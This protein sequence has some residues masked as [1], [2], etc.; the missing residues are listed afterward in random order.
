[1]R[2][3]SRG[4]VA[5][6]ILAASSGFATSDARAGD[7]FEIQVYDATANAPGVPGLE[8]HL[9]Y[10]PTGQRS[11][12][13]PEVPLN[14]QFHATLEPSLGVL[15][16]W[17]LGGY[18]QSAV[19]SNGEVDWAGAKLRSKFVTP[20]GWDPHWR[21]GINVELGYLPPAFDR[22][23]WGLEFRPIAAWQN[24]DWLLAINPI[25]DQSLAG[26]GAPKGPSFEPALKVARTVGGP[27]AL[28]L[29]YYATIGP[30]ASPL[31]VREQEHYIYEVLDV[32]SIPRVEFSAGVGEGLTAASSGV[33]LKMVLGYTFEPAGRA[34]SS[35]GPEGKSGN[36]VL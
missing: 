16:F 36:E 26:P 17:E 12:D 7:P 2:R 5:A 15:P 19:R 1:V 3:A 23:K 22:D 34:E 20:P 31:P 13:P 33:V 6:S 35:R 32:I 24:D 14:G 29:E 27:V 25:V 28:G 30:L 10:W 18:L 8:L 11:S 4:V 9:N 21:L